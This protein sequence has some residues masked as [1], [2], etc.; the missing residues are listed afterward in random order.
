MSATG[1]IAIPLG[2]VP[3]TLQVFGVVLAAL[4][5]SW[6]WAAAALAIY[7][8]MG[9]AGI[10][11]FSMGT[12]GLGVVLGPTG[13]YI[14]GFALAAPA[15]AWLRQMLERRGTAQVV[16]DVVCAAAVVTVVYLLGWVQLAL[17]TNMGLAKALVVGVAPFI[18]P[19]AI[20]AAVAIAIASA[21]RRSG[22]RL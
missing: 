8:V 19:D 15:G 9:A 11:V 13:G 4:L 10:P 3:I 2:P 12:A 14:I 7:V 1:W 20:K 18:V 21:V 16:A 6:E 5:L 17:V 22:V